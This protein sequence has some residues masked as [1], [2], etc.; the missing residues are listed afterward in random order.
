MADNVPIC[1]DAKQSSEEQ[2]KK[3]FKP[4]SQGDASV[5]RTF[6]GTG[7]GLAI[8]MRLAKMLGGGMRYHSELGKGS[9]FLCT[10][11]PGNISTTKL[12]KPELGL[13]RAAE[14]P[15]VPSAD[16]D[17]RVLVVDDRRDV[18]F[19]TKHLL[20][21]AGATVEQAEDGQQALDFYN[22]VLHNRIPN[23][24]IILLDMQMPR[25]DGYQTATEL[26]K[27]GFA[28]PIIALT[29]DAMQ[30]DMNRCIECGCDSYLSKPIDA[31]ALIEKV[32][33]Y[34]RG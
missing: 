12:V 32:R 33:S 15:F 7:L 10:I 6:G 34:L 20:T 23:V 28:N 24:D 16:L 1:A 30:G 17:C 21:R 18:R 4:F 13:V 11:D 2:Q 22:Q 25:I 5:N 8:S 27:R 26:R 19:L 14:Q 3:L 29:A 9:R 31:H